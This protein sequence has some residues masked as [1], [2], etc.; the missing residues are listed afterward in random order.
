MLNIAIRYVMILFLSLYL[1]F[2]LLDKIGNK[3]GDT[4]SF[5]TW[6]ITAFEGEHVTENFKQEIHLFPVSNSKSPS[7]GSAFLTSFMT[8]SV[9][10]LL[11]WIIVTI[12][13]T[14]MITSNQIL[15][16]FAKSINS[17]LELLSGLHVL[18]YGLV[19]YIIFGTDLNVST[20]LLVIGIGSNIYYDLSS[21]QRIFLHST[22]EKDYV[23]FARATG[24]S[25]LKHILRPVGIF[26]ISQLLGSWPS[27]LTNTIFIEII[28]QKSGIGSLLYQNIYAPGQKDLIP[29]V[30]VLMYVSSIVIISI[31]LVSLIKEMVMLRI[32]GDS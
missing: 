20:I 8:T 15:K 5:R 12:I 24:D 9:S 7:V 3:N 29:E 11:I 10:L 4:H 23:L 19:L 27:V 26:S 30:D 1:I 22:L 18:V 2:T 6:M 25:V 28:F 17:A 13:N 14:L 21:E 16:L 32:S 31:L